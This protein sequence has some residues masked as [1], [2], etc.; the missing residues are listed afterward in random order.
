MA[1][2]QGAAAGEVVLVKRER[3]GRSYRGYHK[4]YT[5]VCL[6]G[7]QGCRVGQGTEAKRRIK[8]QC[9][10]YRTKGR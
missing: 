6:S 9:G 10:D 7:L 5:V 4:Y 3:R 8:Q 2:D 1:L